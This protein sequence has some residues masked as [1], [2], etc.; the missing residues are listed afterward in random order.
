MRLLTHAARGLLAMGALVLLMTIDAHA[1]VARRTF[2]AVHVDRGIATFSLGRLDADTV[3][4][5]EVAW[6]GG[7]RRLPL[8]R[9]RTAA[10]RGVLR[11]RTPQI[12]KPRLIVT[13]K[14]AH[15]P[16]T[17]PSSG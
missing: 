9:V 6:R 16:G 5:G 15:A 14:A 4:G 2:P 7:S 11:V 8:Q 3:L 1:S 10:R 17:A 12:R 13:T